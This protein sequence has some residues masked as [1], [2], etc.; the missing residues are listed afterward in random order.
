MPYML[1][2]R[3]LAGSDLPDDATWKQDLPDSGMVTAFE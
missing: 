2:R 1:R 3:I